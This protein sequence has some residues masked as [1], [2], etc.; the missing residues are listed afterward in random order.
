MPRKTN[1]S[2]N[3]RSGIV[4]SPFGVSCGMLWG[5]EGPGMNVISSQ[6]LFNVL[7][8]LFDAF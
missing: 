8:K 7:V 5:L 6:L 2:G 4:D 3:C 1:A